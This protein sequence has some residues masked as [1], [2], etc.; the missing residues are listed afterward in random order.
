VL[1]YG[2]TLDL[3]FGVILGELD[4]NFATVHVRRGCPY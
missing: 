1:V 4:S 2:V 3:I